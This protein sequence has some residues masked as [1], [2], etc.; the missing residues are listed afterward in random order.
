MGGGSALPYDAEVEYIQTD[1]K[2]FI[3]TGIKTSSN[4]TFDLNLYIPSHGTQGV[5][6]FGS[7]VSASSG[8]M[9]YLNDPSHNTKDWRYHNKATTSGTILSSGNY[10]FKNTASVNVLKINDT[11]TLSAPSA[12]F[13]SDYNFYILTLNVAGTPA[14][15]NIGNGAR[16]MP[17]KIYLSGVLV[18]D[19]IAV[20]KDGVGYLYDKV[21]GKLFGNANSEG[22]FSYGADIVEIEYLESDGTQYIVTDVYPSITNTR[23]T[24]D[25]QYTINTN[26]QLMGAGFSNN[27]RFNIGISSGK[28]RMGLGS[29]WFDVL[30]PRDL[31]R[32]K[33]I[34]ENNGTSYSAS[35]DNTTVS[36]SVTSVADIETYPFVVN[37]RGGVLNQT[38]CSGKLYGFSVMKSGTVVLDLIPVRIGQVGYMRDKIS[39]KLYGNSG[40]GSFILGSD[41]V[42]S[43]GGKHLVINMLC[44]LSVER[45]AA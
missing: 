36:G 28:F 43:G 12:T 40:T 42:A 9:G 18:R 37:V 7:R 15:I 22:A 35:I 6:M 21:S 30:N 29:T 34:L 20:R 10:N 33:W 3:D 5:W 19:Y 39:G 31:D 16:I 11:I 24:I 41:K 45:R 1:G 38:K 32:H 27:N 14:L 17:S 2:A 23:M 44:G 25:Y 8:Q 26:E 13:T 4:L